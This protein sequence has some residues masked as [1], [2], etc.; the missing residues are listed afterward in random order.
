MQRRCRM[1]LGGI[2]LVLLIFVLGMG[3]AAGTLAWIMG[4]KNEQVQP[5]Q[6]QVWPEEYIE[7]EELPPRED[8]WKPAI[9]YSEAAKGTLFPNQ[10]S[11]SFRIAADSSFQRAISRRDLEALAATD[12]STEP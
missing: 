12:G 6:E 2:A 1:D 11:P 3:L 7:G 4:R 9:W 5:N 8:A 10:P